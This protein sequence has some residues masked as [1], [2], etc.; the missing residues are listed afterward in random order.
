MASPQGESQASVT[1]SPV[2]LPPVNRKGV[3]DGSV[4]IRFR[5]VEN[6]PTAAMP[7]VR[8]TDVAGSSYTVQA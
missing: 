4:S 7:D 3:S 2:M 1:E 8:C 5:F 6:D